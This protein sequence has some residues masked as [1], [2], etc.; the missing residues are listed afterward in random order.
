MPNHKFLLSALATSF[1]AG[2]ATEDGIV[3]RAGLALGRRWRWLRPIA[4]RY[5][6]RFSSKLRPRHQEVVHFLRDDPSFRRVWAKHSKELS[7]ARWVTGAQKMRPVEAA[8]A[9][10][11][12]KLESVHA[13][14]EWLHL[15][16]SELEWF[17]DLK[18]FGEKSGNER[19]RHYHYRVLPKKSG[20]PRL[21]EAPKDFL[22]GLQRKILHNILDAI[23]VHPA[24]HGFVKGR[25]I[26]TFA[27]PH[28]GHRA[29]L[30]MDL[31][32][33]FP[34]IRARRIQTFFR[35]AGYPEAVADL[36][37][38]LCTNA[39]PSSVWKRGG[40]AL[41]PFAL[42]EVQQ[43]YGRVHLPQGA[44]TSPALANLCAYRVDCRLNGLAQAAGAVYTRY[45]DDLAF[46]GNHEF[47][48]CAER[49][50]ARAAAILIEE[51]FEVHHRKTR[52]M[53]RGV[54]PHLA[55]LVANEH[56]NVV[57]TDFDRLKAT[58]TNCVRHGPES[59]NR[60]SRPMFRMHLEGRIAFVEM[61]N[62]QRGARL[63]RIF[64]KIQWP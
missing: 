24:V 23:P 10:K 28:T 43:L 25:S 59:Q 3:D 51:G 63:R 47:D 64:E 26:K 54:R 30:R 33:F 57:R 46:S 15:T 20:N 6:D 14:A 18:G 38:A 62:P 35:T 42:R 45:A 12:P 55:G 53:R 22:K 1:L 52:I 34:S 13:L 58:L 5:L 32:D 60:E 56:V 36:L 19:L 39:A 17:C 44:P 8:A 31:K 41:G 49:F 9:W 16:E 27:A 7:I 40:F 50:V 29:V 61:I 48:R 4:R 21:V 37:G 11:V 2:D